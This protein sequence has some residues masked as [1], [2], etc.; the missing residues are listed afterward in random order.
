MARRAWVMAALV[1]G[2]LSLSGCGKG[3]SVGPP[4]IVHTVSDRT[5]VGLAGVRVQVKGQAWVTSDAAGGSRFAA[6]GGP[7]T[8]LV[9]QDLFDGGSTIETGEAVFV[10]EEQIGNDVVVE[11]DGGPGPNAAVP[12]P[13]WHPARVTG[14]VSGRSSTAGTAW[15]QVSYRGMWMPAHV[16]VDGSFDLGVLF[17]DGAAAVTV[18]AFEGSPGPAN[19][20]T[21]LDGFAAEAVS[22]VAGG[23]AAGVALALTPVAT[24]TVAGSA[25]LAPGLTGAEVVGR[26]SLG[27]GRYAAES[28]SSISAAVS[29]AGFSLPVPT[30]AGAETWVAVTAAGARPPSGGGHAR[31]VAPPATGVDFAVPAAVDLLEPPNGGLVDATTVFRW[32]GGE[33]GG[34]FTLEASCSWPAGPVTRTIEYHLTTPSTQASLP[35]IADFALAPDA[36]CTWSVTWNADASPAV[37][38]RWSRSEVRTAT[39]R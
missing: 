36:A 11:V 20:V 21:Q 38:R 34:A 9:H 4:L 12:R 6:P 5:G 23:H 15:V 25:S 10:L 27:F 28:V 8:I 13:S 17:E 33:P 26:W 22:L 18:R 29:P 3:T 16:A 19:H 1:G 37:E 39:S 32:S 30:L 7:F 2:E 35:D 14:T 24:S 31:L